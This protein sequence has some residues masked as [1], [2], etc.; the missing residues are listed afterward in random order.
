MKL[1]HLLS[2]PE[3][4][5]GTTSGSNPAPDAGKS[6]GGA[7]EGTPDVTDRVTDEPVVD[8]E[9]DWDALG[10]DDDEA[11]QSDDAQT[12]GDDTP[13]PS[14]AKSDEKTSPKPG[15]QP[16]ADQPGQT[17]KQDQSDDKSDEVP[18][19]PQPQPQETPEQKAERE[20]LAKEAEEKSF[21]DLK[22]YYELPADMA[23]RLSTEPELVLPEMAARVHQAVFKGIQQY[24]TQVVPLFLQQHAQVQEANQK[25]K[26][27]FFG[28]WP[29]LKGHDARVLEV[30]RMYAQMNPKATPA[31]RLETVGQIACAALG[32]TPDP[33]PSGK[34]DPQPKPG[35]KKP[36][37]AGF[38]PT[39]PAGSSSAALPPSDNP[40]EAMAEE[41]LDEDRG[42]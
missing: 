34:G 27:A 41:F 10:K 42:P 20:R 24:M 14:S 17:G 37:A 26:E 33:A 28:R 12:T 8:G 32:I 4:T 23:E 13:S 30:G 11:P 18:A 39:N 5:Q 9:Q 40:Y 29:S 31:E 6:N 36:A 1:E 3:S 35:V 19:Q 16:Q 2:S 25:S 22:K 7:P 21:A 15:D 38:R